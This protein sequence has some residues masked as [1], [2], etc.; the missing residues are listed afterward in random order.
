M[1]RRVHVVLADDVDGGVAA[2]TIAFGV[3]GVSYEIDL[4][5]ENAALLREEL[6]QWVT[7]ARRTGGRKK[8]KKST[9]SADV[10][11]I[12]AWAQQQGMEISDR[13]RIPTPV[14]E[15]YAAAH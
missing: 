10:A 14:R 7:A 13:G 15:A 8:T 6:G 12:R 3:D 9:T 4:S 5:E 11:E 1:A 2:E